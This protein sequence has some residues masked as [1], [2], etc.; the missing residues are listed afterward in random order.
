MKCAIDFLEWA[1]HSDK[2]RWAAVLSGAQPLKHITQHQEIGG[3]ARTTPGHHTPIMRK[4]L[5]ETLLCEPDVPSKTFLS[6]LTN[7]KKA[8]SFIFAFI[9][10]IRLH[11]LS[12]LYEFTKRVCVCV[13]YI[14]HD[15][16]CVEQK[17]G[18]VFWEKVRCLYVLYSENTTENK[19]LCNITHR[20]LV[21]HSYL[22][23]IE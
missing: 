11:T 19:H 6:L 21:L 17:L 9:K 14:K 7:V 5:S 12:L 16:C 22:C 8:Y 2:D 15:L 10:T 20:A 13:V 23:V 18:F 4:Y 3:T 1:M